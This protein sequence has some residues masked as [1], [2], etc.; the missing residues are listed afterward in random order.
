MVNR[1]LRILIATHSPLAAEFGAGQ[2]AINLAEALREQGHHVTL[3]SPHPMPILT[4]PWRGIQSFKIM[5]SKL[6]AFLNTQESFD[7]I[8]SFALL[9][10]KQVAKSA[11]VVARSVQPEIWYIPYKLNYPRN[12]DLKKLAFLPFRYLLEVPYLFLLLQGWSRANYILCLG[13][14]ELEWMKKW[15]PWWRGKLISYLHAL[16]KNDQ[17]ELSKISLHRKKYEGKDIRFL[18]IGRWVAHKGIS[19]LLDFIVKRA[20]SHPQDTFTIAGCGFDAEKDCP[21]ELL[22]SGQLKILPSFERSQLYFL[23]V[24]HDVGLFT[25]SV[26]GWGLVLNEM[27]ESGM[28]I[29]ATPAGGIPDLEPLFKESIKPFPPPLELTLDTITIPEFKNEYYQTFSWPTIGKFYLQFIRK[30]LL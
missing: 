23:L 28:P 16:S 24:N 26:E 9:I 21:L 4:T 17:A 6:D 8:D 11:L 14:L 30:N 10:T 15:F 20:V 25:S 2:V 22:E 7:V 3:W 1:P 19:T 12:W 13:S 5:R 18:W 29:F 27:L